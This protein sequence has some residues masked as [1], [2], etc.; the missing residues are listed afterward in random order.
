M[1]ET[2]ELTMRQKQ[3]LVSMD[4]GMR[5]ELRRPL[6]FDAPWEL[7]TVPPSDATVEDFLAL[8]RAGFVKIPNPF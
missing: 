8:E 5:V 4:E 6:N 2:H 1:A 7:R 3:L